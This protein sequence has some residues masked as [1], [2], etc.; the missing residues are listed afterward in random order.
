MY[1]EPNWTESTLIVRFNYVTGIHEEREEYLI[2]TPSSLFADIGGYLGLLLG[3][4][5]Y[6]VFC[7]LAAL[8]RARFAGG[9]TKPKAEHVHE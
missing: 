4:S 5:I 7:D 8:F 3:H 6:S 1:S 2:Y 9:R